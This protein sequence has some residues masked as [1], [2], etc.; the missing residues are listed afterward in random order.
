M[1]IRLRAV[2]MWVLLVALPF[3]GFAA[4][5]MLGCGPS[6]HPVSVAALQEVAPA[7]SDHDHQHGAPGDHHH[8]DKAS[9][10]S[11]CAACCVSAALPAAS[12]VF[13]AMATADVPSSL[14]S[15]GA[16]GFLTGGPDR[17]P[18]SFLV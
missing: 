5:S 12:L 10:C 16:V 3:Q 14:L 8:A 9:K 11:V 15:M 2:L 6:H 4:A 13:A 7:A 17:P 18:R 1:M